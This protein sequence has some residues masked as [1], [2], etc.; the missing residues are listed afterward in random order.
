MRQAI[1][2]MGV[3]RLA[4]FM[5]IHSFCAETMKLAVRYCPR[6]KDARFTKMVCGKFAL[7][8]AFQN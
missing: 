8:L 3:A 7:N 1:S 4:L 6:Q 5:P 2:E